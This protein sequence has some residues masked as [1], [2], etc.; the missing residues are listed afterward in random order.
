MIDDLLGGA[1]D[2]VRRPVIA[3]ERPDGLDR[4][5]SGE[6]GGKGRS[7]MV[8]GPFSL[9]ETGQPAWSSSS[10]AC[11]PG[12]TAWLISSNGA[13]MAFVS[14]EGR[15]RPAPLPFF[16][17]RAPKMEAQAVRGSCG[18]EGRVPRRAQRRVPLVRRPDPG[19][20][21]PPQLDRGAVRQ[22]RL[23]RFPFSGQAFFNA[24]LSRS[25]WA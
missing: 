16:G 18:A 4:F 12:A 8:S 24:S 5:N 15:T 14:Q 3:N 11:A 2:P 17:Q 9:V 25:F 13:A 10:T 22:T 19:L 7:V 6:Q 23:D 20:V 21:M 1:E